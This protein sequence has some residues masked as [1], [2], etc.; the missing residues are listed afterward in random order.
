M[1]DFRLGDIVTELCATK[2]YAAYNFSPEPWNHQD[3]VP[4][5]ARE[6]GHISRLIPVD[7]DPQPGKDANFIMAALAQGTL[8]TAGPTRGCPPS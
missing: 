1:N 8:T 5:R 7:P 6:K 4:R 3:L 2:R